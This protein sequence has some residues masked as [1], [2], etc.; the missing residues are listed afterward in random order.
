ME[1]FLLWHPS[2]IT[3]KFRPDSKTKSNNRINLSEISIANRRLSWN[4]RELILW[5]RR[6]QLILSLKK[7]QMITKWVMH[8]ILQPT[9]W[10]EGGA[11]AVRSHN[12]TM[13]SAKLQ[14]K[15]WRK[16]LMKSL[17]LLIQ[18]IIWAMLWL[19]QVNKISWARKLTLLQFYQQRVQMLTSICKTRK[20]RKSKL[21]L[22]HSINRPK[23]KQN[24]LGRCHHMAISRLPVALLVE[25][26]NLLTIWFQILMT[27]KKSFLKFSMTILRALKLLRLIWI[28]RMLL[29]RH[30][31]WELRCSAT[32]N[33]KILGWAVKL[34]DR[35]LDKT[36]AT[37]SACPTPPK[38]SVNP[39][40][41]Q[42]DVARSCKLLWGP[43]ECMVIEGVSAKA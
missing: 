5:N 31:S 39:I 6:R 17:R 42:K 27:P 34:Q 32:G 20:K 14:D 3:R 36:K 15:W 24:C 10:W 43:K 18:K 2:E 35:S 21:K 13:I 38:S 4:S 22:S 9:E 33:L 25:I 29:I 1:V 28:S 8:L 30:R 11:N 41:Y 12:L 7:V 19:V 26:A 37:S 40:T 23:H 16:R